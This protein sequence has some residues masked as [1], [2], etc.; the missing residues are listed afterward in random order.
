MVNQ[1]QMSNRA[2]RVRMA[3]PRE[4]SGGAWVEGWDVCAVLCT[5]SM[6]AAG[7]SAT[8]WTIDGATSG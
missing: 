1:N 8:T 6:S 2:M 7:I 5:T 4:V 3:R